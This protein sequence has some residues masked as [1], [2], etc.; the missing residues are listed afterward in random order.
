MRNK[1]GAIIEKEFYGYL[2]IAKKDL[3]KIEKIQEKVH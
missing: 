3:L 1:E 2:D